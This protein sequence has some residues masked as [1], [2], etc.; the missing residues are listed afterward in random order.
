MSLVIRWLFVLTLA[1]LPVGNSIACPLWMSSVDAARAKG[2]CHQQGSDSK[3][4]PATVCQVE[5]PY[6]LADRVSPATPHAAPVVK[7]L[8]ATASALI[9]TPPV[10]TRTILPAERIAR[11]SSEPLFLRIRVLLI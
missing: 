9:S 10:V 11:H 7:E 6:L 2:R 4:C 3:H 1:G 8:P 5:A